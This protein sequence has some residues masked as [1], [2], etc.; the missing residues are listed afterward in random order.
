MK[1]IRSSLLSCLLA[2]TSAH[3]ADQKICYLALIPFDIH[4]HIAKF[5]DFDYCETKDEFIARTIALKKAGFKSYVPYEIYSTYLG[6]F[7]S[8]TGSSGSYAAYCP[9][10]TK[11]AIFEGVYGGPNNL[12]PKIML[13][14]VEK[15]LVLH[16]EDGL[17][18]AT[19]EVALSRT[20]KKFAW[21][22]QS[23]LR[24]SF[25][26]PKEPLNLTV[27]SITNH[28]AQAFELPWCAC[29]DHD[30]VAFNKQGTQIIVHHVDNMTDFPT[31]TCSFAKQ[32]YTIFPL[33]TPEEIANVEQK[34]LLNYL[35]YKGVCKPWKV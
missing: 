1:L 4:I 35:Y 8:G 30:R 16:T 20:G 26:L 5:L 7:E 33:A 6:K 12:T 31:P 15:E 29:H 2:I 22:R 11:M 27:K 3:A 28:T 21:L 14:H 23:L 32:S 18:T 17:S 25:V 24:L 19:K 34:T 13:V 9:D 10:K